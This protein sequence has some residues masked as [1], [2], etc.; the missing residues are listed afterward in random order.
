MKLF[1]IYIKKSKNEAVQDLVMVKNSFSFSA[2][3][4]NIFW[5]L[6]HK[7]WKESLALV[8][9]GTLFIEVVYKDIFEFFDAAILI[10]GLLLIIAINAGYWYGENLKARGY[11]FFGCVFGKNR[12]EAKIRFIENYFQKDTDIFC[13]SIV[14]L[15]K[16]KESTERHFT[17]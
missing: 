2:F 16:F 6:Q 4:F 17:A 10:F 9:V 8:L 14:D 11:Q 15:K 7:M 3:F 13:E 5:F 1:S 12:D